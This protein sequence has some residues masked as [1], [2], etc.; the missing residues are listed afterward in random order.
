L[1]IV[2]AEDPVY[3]PYL[4]GAPAGVLQVPRTVDSL[5]E[6]VREIDCGRR[7][8]E[9]QRLELAEFARSRYSL[10]PW[11]ERH[12]ELYAELVQA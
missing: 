6:A 1:P 2:L 7:I 8:E 5:V 4:E 9:G 12:E 3:K 10:G 11:A